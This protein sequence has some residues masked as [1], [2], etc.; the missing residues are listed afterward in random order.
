MVIHKYPK[1]ISVF[2]SGTVKLEAGGAARASIT[3]AHQLTMQTNN[4]KIITK[5]KMDSVNKFAMQ[6]DPKIGSFLG[7]FFPKKLVFRAPKSLFY[8]KFT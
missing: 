5:F 2:F 7:G 3:L 1:K 4:A 6:R 8:Y